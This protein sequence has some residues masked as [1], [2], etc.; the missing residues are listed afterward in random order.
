MRVY[1]YMR[2]SYAG[3]SDARASRTGEPIESVASVLYDPV[4]MARRFYL[5]ENLCL[6]SLMAQTNQNFRMIVLASDI[7]PDVYKERLAAVTSDV[8]QIEIL[9]SSAEHVTDAFNPRMAELVAG[10]AGPTAHFRLDDDDAIAASMVA[11]LE[12]A[13]GLA[14]QV[15]VVSFPNGLYLTHQDGQSYL[16]REY[17]PFIGIGLAFLNMPG[18]IQNPYQCKHA[19]VNRRYP[20]FSDPEPIGYIHSAHDSSDTVSRQKTKF[21]KMLTSN[22]NHDS[23]LTKAEIR[24][25]VRDEFVGQTVASLMSVIRKASLIGTAQETTTA[26]GPQQRLR[27]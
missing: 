26:S 9:Y 1:G 25:A 16:L 13:L 4:R 10:I 12:A 27:S 20:A 3:K 15:R 11:R 14:P 2:F 18:Q 5:F 24:A 17:F 7:M 8:P 19:E 22:P 23:R 6:P 21:L